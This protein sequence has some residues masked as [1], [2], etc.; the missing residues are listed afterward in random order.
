VIVLAGFMGAGKTT[1][2]RL[3]AAGAGAAFLDSDQ[4]VED[5]AGRT[6]AQIF[7]VGGEPAFR[8]LEHEVIAGLLGEGPGLVLAIGGGAVE[9]EGTRKLLAPVPVAF[10]RVS[11][12]QAMAR[13][14]GDDTRPLLA[15]PGLP[16]VYRRRQALYQ[17]IATITV[18]VD[19]MSPQDVAERV[20]A[21]LPA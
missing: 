12:Q 19:D 15:R 7:A 10:L 14:G 20:R 5:R 16:G 6:I 2:G 9:H 11:Y 18:D 3:L 1:V 17:D 8:G 21:R 13:V 4:V